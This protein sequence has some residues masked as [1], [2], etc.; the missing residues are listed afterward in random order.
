M[1][2]YTKKSFVTLKTGYPVVVVIYKSFGR[3]RQ[4]VM[5]YFLIVID[6]MAE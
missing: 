5:P 4:V 6:A 1:S 3:Q 2:N